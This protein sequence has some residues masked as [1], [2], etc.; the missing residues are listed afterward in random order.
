MTIEALPP[1]GLRWPTCGI[2]PATCHPSSTSARRSGAIWE[3][4][5]EWPG[6]TDN[7]TPGEARFGG[8]TTRLV[9]GA[10]GLGVR[11]VRET[12]GTPGERP[13][14]EGYIFPG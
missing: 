9:S 2:P 14:S 12:L 3:L 10:A 4:I 8:G 6:G 5:R 7:H 13:G 11:I 1:A